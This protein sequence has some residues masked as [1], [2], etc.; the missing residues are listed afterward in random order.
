M[1]PPRIGKRAQGL[2]HAVEEL[3]GAFDQCEEADE[4]DEELGEKI[5]NLK[6]AIDKAAPYW[7]PDKSGQDESWGENAN[8]MNEAKDRY[9]ALRMFLTHKKE[10]E[11][12]EKQDPLSS[13]PRQLDTVEGGRSMVGDSVSDISSSMMIAAY[14]FLR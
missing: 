6:N 4:H 7:H 9:Q 2:K 10:A 13:N 11:A 1:H 8:L 3:Q 14:I 5:A 12:E